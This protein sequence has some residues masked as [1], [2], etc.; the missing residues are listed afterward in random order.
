MN[1]SV[2]LSKILDIL[3][4]R[5]CYICSKKCS[6][7]SICEDCLDKINSNLKFHKVSKFNTTVYCG[8]VYEDELLKI[9]RALK[10]HKKQE[11]KKIL[12][13]I[14]I[15]TIKNYEI[16]LDGFVI[17]PVPIHKN[18]FNK[19]KYNHMELVANEIAQQ[20]N[21]E[22]RTDLLTRVKDTQPLYKLSIPER[23]KVIKGA[24]E[25][26]DDIKGKK[27]L[28]VDDI[29]TSGTTVNELSSLILEKEPS[30]FIVICATRSNNC[31]F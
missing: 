29:I 17:C 30:E 15:S 10:Y 28:L 25:A 11:F 31:N 16:N 7:I 3:Y 8:A 1:F 12:S 22:V 14:I 24:F 6:E 26:N 23:K 9:I 18:R 20:L 4:Y 13:D 21:L 19:R 27:I 2:I 5:S